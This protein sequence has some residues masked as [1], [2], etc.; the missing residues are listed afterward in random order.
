MMGSS[1]CG[2]GAGRC[3]HDPGQDVKV[4]DLGKGMITILGT[5]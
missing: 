3:G 5:M 2:P 1:F 4:H